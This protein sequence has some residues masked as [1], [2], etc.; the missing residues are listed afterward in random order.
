M[1]KIKPM[2]A[3]NAPEHIELPMLAS[4]KIDGIRCMIVSGV[5][6]SRNLKP[7]R[8]RYVQQCLAGLPHGLDGELVVG[9]PGGEGVFRRTS[10]GVMSIKGEPDFTFWVFDNFDVGGGFEERFASL[11]EQH[12]RVR[13]VPHYAIESHEALEEFEAKTLE[14]GFEGV[15]LRKP[16]GPYKWGRSSKSE[17]YLLKLKRFVDAEAEVLGAVEL[18]HNHNVAKRNML[19]RLERSSAKAGKVAGGVLGALL[20]RDIVTGVEFRIGGGFTQKEREQLWKQR[21]SLVGRL[22]KYK[23]FAGG[24][25]TAPRFPIFLGFRDRADM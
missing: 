13:I 16:S 8:N 19:G 6:V 14:H 9:Q 1:S 21:R 3:C 11:S 22:A 18:R 4:P 25:K 2:L 12:P 15:M 20:V 17:G 10:S 24:V 7:I 5:A 23:Y